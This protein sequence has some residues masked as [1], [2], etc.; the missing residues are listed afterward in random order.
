MIWACTSALSLAT[1]STPSFLSSSSTAAARNRDCVG[2]RV[3][4]LE[5]PLLDG[6]DLDADSDGLGRPIHELGRLQHVDD[7]HVVHGV[8]HLVGRDLLGRE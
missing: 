6:L 3:G 1:G 4:Q 2:D 7:A 8:L 5:D